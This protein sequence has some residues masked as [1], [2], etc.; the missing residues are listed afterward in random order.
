M[1]KETCNRTK[2]TA[3]N[4][5]MQVTKQVNKTE[6]KT[7]LKNKRKVNVLNAHKMQYNIIQ[8]MQEIFSLKKNHCIYLQAVNWRKNEKE[9]KLE[10][11]N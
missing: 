9:E 10:N 6:V 7:K 11:N 4:G 1:I 5:N 3:F 8:Y 2:E